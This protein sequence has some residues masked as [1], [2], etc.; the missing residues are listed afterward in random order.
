MLAGCKGRSGEAVPLLQVRDHNG[1]ASGAWV[2][3]LG[4]K[5]RRLVL[6]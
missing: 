2:F 5:S 3:A 1:L 4:T 6:E